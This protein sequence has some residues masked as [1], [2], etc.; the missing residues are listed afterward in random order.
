MTKQIINYLIYTTA[1]LLYGMFGTNGAGT[2]GILIIP[3]LLFTIILFVYNLSFTFLG[4][5]IFSKQSLL[6][7]QL[8][9]PQLIGLIIFIVLSF[10]NKYIINNDLDKVLWGFL[11][12]TTLLNIWT[13]LILKKD[14]AAKDKL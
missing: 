4:Q 12:L 14:E 6:L 11:I 13:Y 9:T 7:L 10:R 1:G 8:L 5:F 3:I 2:T